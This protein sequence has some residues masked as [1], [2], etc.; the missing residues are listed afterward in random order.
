M[1][2]SMGLVVVEWTGETAHA[3]QR[4]LR[5]TN[6]SFAAKLGVAV[7]T[8]ASWRNNPK[9]VPR[10]GMQQLLDIT[11]ERASTV[12]RRRFELIL[13]PPAAAPADVRGAMDPVEAAELSL[14]QAR[15][16]ELQG[17]L[18]EL[19]SIRDRIVSRS[20]G[21]QPANFASVLRPS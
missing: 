5:M 18:F 11:Y 7:R 12:A 3:L 4:A 13:Q 2:E 10:E 6:E 16:D 17:S 1:S 19:Q 20:T 15:M 14:L 9:I 8:V 21:S